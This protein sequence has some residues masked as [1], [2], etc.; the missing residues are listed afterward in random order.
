M[1]RLAAQGHL[2][3][4]P[5]PVSATNAHAGWRREDNEV[6][7]E[8]LDIEQRLVGQ[9]LALFGLDRADDEHRGVGGE[10]ELLD[11]GAGVDDGC[12]SSFIVG[13]AVAEDLACLHLAS[14]RVEAPGAAVAD[15]A[16]VNVRV[17]DDSRSAVAYHPDN[18]TESVHLSDRIPEA[19]HLL[20]HVRSDA[21]F[22]AAGRGDGDELP[23]ELGAALAV[24]L[25]SRDDSF[26]HLIHGAL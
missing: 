9:A 5:A 17:E 14:K 11:D 8:L 16:G 7:I 19:Q 6:R 12:E 22:L 18:I 3:L 13:G 4:G 2:D 24:P 20:A 1:H 21:V 15:D 10:V 26:S 25:G 23:E